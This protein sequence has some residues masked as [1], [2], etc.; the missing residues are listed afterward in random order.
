MWAPSRFWPDGRPVGGRNG[1]PDE[2]QAWNL[3][4]QAR[5]VA[6]RMKGLARQR[7]RQVEL[8]HWKDKMPGL[9]EA[10]VTELMRG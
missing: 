10:R 1:Y 4:C 8:D 6:K 5:Y 3:E 9:D 2:Y 7:E